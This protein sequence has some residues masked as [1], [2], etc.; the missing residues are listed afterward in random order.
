VIRALAA[1]ALGLLV[2]VAAAAYPAA[3]LVLLVRLADPIGTLWVN[4]IRMTVIPLV[5]SLL[6]VGVCASGEARAVRA[7]GLRA[8]A[9][10][11]SLMVFAAL[12]SMVL[13]PPLFA[14]LHVDPAAAAALRGA[15]HVETA[16][17]AVPGVADWLVGLVPA[18]PIKAAADGAMLP[19]VVFT[20]AFALALLTIRPERRE[21]V[22]GFFRGVAD[23]MMAI[24]QGVIRLT[25][26]GVFALMLTATSR[27]GLSTAGALGYYI[28]ATAISQIVMIGLLYLVVA[29]AARTPPM[30]FARAVLPAQ[31]VAFS[32][33]SSLASLPALIDGA[34]ERLKLPA[35]VTGLVL[36]LAVASFKIGGPVL[37][38]VAALFLGKLYGVPVTTAQ[39]AV[40]TMT[41][42]L[43]SFSAPGVPHGWLLVLAPVIASIGIPA[44]GVGLLIAVDA[45]PD[46]FATT[47]NVT[48]DMAAVAMVARPGGDLGRT[49]EQRSAAVAPAPR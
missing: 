23:A 38:P 29:F 8:I 7:L 19:L 27:T 42:L 16:P 6:V 1:L 13:V 48:G 21:A 30:H 34:R 36:P 17:A 35:D 32:S 25:P 18:N 26:V 41:G 37:Y 12:V 2:G 20:A 44:E 14:W 28:A 49:L 5:V 39:L 10:F 11:F 31:A 9:V 22:V 4:A 47:L 45:V 40:V 3:P 46:M 24:V 43:T 15:D 33:S